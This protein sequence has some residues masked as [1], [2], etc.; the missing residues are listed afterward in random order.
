MNIHY[1]FPFA[2]NDI[3]RGDLILQIILL[4]KKRNIYVSKNPE[5]LG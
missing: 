4:L 2:E 5:Y 3:L 1:E